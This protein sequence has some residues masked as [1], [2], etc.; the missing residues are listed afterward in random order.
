[1][2]H[3]EEI[4]EKQEEAT[5]VVENEEIDLKQENQLLKQKVRQLTGENNRWEKKISNLSDKLSFWENEDLISDS[6]DKIKINEKFKNYFA[7]EV[8]KKDKNF[9]SSL[10]ENK[11]DEYFKFLKSNKTYSAFFDSKEE[12]QV[13]NNPIFDYIKCLIFPRFGKFELK[14]AEKYGGDKTYNTYE[15]MCEDYLKGD[16]FPGDVKPNVARLINDMIEPVRKHFENDPEAKKILK[17]VKSFKVT[18]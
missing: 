4:Q 13:E 17:L 3:S 15:E 9:Y 1:M 14:R 18:R 5:P 6:L 12:K 11:L 16:L 7:K 8:I 10:K 2:F